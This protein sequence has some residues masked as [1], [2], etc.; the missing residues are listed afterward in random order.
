[1]KTPAQIKAWLQRPTR[2]S[3]DALYKSETLEYIKR[4]ESVVAAYTLRDGKL[5]EKDGYTEH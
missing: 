5:E 2:V 4:L 1:M 3:R